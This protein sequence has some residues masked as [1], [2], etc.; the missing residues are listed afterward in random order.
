MDSLIAVL[1]IGKTHAKLILVEE[2]S[3][4]IR[5][6]KQYAC[7]PVTGGDFRELD[8]ARLEAWFIENLRA[9]PERERI[10]HLFPV[11]H[12]AAAVWLDEK[13]RRIAAPDYE[14]AIFDS[15]AEGYRRLR[16]NYSDTYSPFLS[17]GLNLGRQYYF[18]ESRRPDIFNQARWALL[19]PQYWAWRFSGVAAS[20]ITSLGCHSDLWRPSESRPSD[21]AMRQGWERLRPPLR[22]AGHVL[23]VVT[24]EIVRA[25]GLD[26]KCLVYCGM[27]DSNASYLCHF[28]KERHKTASNAPA[29]T[30]VSSGTWIVVLTQIASSLE[31]LREP[32]DMLANIDAYGNPVATARFMGGREYAEIAG[33]KGCEVAP[34]RHWLFKILLEEAMALPSF[35][36]LGGPYAGCKGTFLHADRIEDA[37]ARA[38]LATLYLALMTDLL[39]DN[40]GARGAIIVDGPLTGNPMFNDVLQTLRRDSPV[41]ASAIPHAPAAAAHFLVTGVAP[42]AEREIATSLPNSAALEDYRA[43]WR[44]RIQKLDACAMQRERTSSV[45]IQSGSSG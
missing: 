30:V 11:A 38:T 19:Y 23:G 13:G 8:I 2:G 32:L 18:F 41:Y 27:H 44:T 14:D 20:E 35:S 1:D 6:E 15:V 25:T 10:R 16:D 45:L 29:F 39:L 37:A 7:Q 5:W 17:S 43:E 22:R 33:A 34:T 21:L 28:T 42:N 26:P 4:E 40:I 36:L 31:R 9:A 12:G 24:P 3:G